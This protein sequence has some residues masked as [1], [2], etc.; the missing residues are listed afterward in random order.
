MKDRRRRTRTAP[1]RSSRTTA[2][3]PFQGPA[4]DVE[5]VAEDRYAGLGDIDL[6]AIVPSPARVLPTTSPVP[7][8]RPAPASTAL[9][10]LFGD[11][12]DADDEDDDPE[13][14][15]RAALLGG[16][17]STDTPVTPFQGEL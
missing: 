17:A 10:G 13:Q 16:D 7:V 14:E 15:Q 3:P 5:E 6:D 8:Q 4:L 1:P 2:L 12:T 11:D 9:A